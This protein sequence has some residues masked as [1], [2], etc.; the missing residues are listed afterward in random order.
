MTDQRVEAYLSNWVESTLFLNGKPFSFTMF[1]PKRVI[2]DDPSDFIVEMTSRQVGKS[3][4]LAAIQIGLTTAIPHFHTLYIAPQSKHKSDFSHQRLN[5]LIE[6]SPFIKMN[7]TSYRLVNNVDLKQFTNDSF[8]LLKHAYL[9]DLPLRGPSSDLNLWDEYQN[10]NPAIFNVGQETLNRSM[11]KRTMVAGTPRTTIT[12]LHKVWEAST[13]YEVFYKCEGC[14]HWNLPSMKHVKFEGPSCE[15]CGKIIT[16]EK[17][18]WVCTGDPKA[19]SSG[20]HYNKLGLAI[21][22]DEATIWKKDVWNK[23]NGPEGERKTLKE[24]KNEVLGEPDDDSVRPITIQDVIDCCDTQRDVYTLEGLEKN[25]YNMKEIKNYPM[26]CAID[27]GTTNTATSNT[28]LILGAPKSNDPEKIKVFLIKKFVGEESSYEYILNYIYRIYAAVPSIRFFSADNGM[29]AAPNSLIRNRL[30]FEKL[31]GFQFVPN[32][33]DK[34]KWHV[35]QG[36]SQEE[37]NAYYTVSKVTAYDQ[38]FYEIKD[39]M[40]DFPMWD[41]FGPYGKEICNV[42]QQFNEE[43][44]KYLY[45]H[46]P[47]NPDDV[48]STLIYLR[49]LI[50]LS[51]GL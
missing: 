20:Y 50:E 34:V 14:G 19:E 15:K 39:S 25:A 10:Q 44:S 23:L 46:A 32:Q 47:E 43:K 33:K 12:P 30:G 35:V 45:T 3:T 21:F 49:L 17:W 29:G 11:Y 2:Y 4:D 22:G 37:I 16:A 13:K 28:V 5:P 1:P 48:P 31:F 18:E 27:W 24:F 42:E 41:Q 38:F 51:A 6:S 7:Y 26:Y 36:T 8:I 40:W 9:T